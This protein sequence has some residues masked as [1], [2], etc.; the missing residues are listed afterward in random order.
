MIKLKRDK[1]HKYQLAAIDFIKQKKKCALFLDMGLGKTAL[2]LTAVSDFLDDFAVSRVLVIAPLRVANTVWTQE[3]AKW[4]HLEHLTFAVCTG[5]PRERK[6][7]LASNVDI[8]VINRENVSWLVDCVKWRW[9]MVIVD[10]STSFKNFNTMRS[11]ALR[12]VVKYFRYTVLLTG[13]PSPNSLMDL[14][15]QLYL[16]DRGERL[17][18]TIGEY[19]RR[20]F[21][22]DGFTSY[23]YEA[24][25]D[26]END[27]K[28]LIKDVC[29]S[30]KSADY[31][32]LP[33]KVVVRVA[34]ELP[35]QMK[36]LYDLFEKEFLLELENTQVE[37]LTTAAL[38]NKLLQICN[39][40]VY[41]ADKVPHVMHDAKI[42][43]LRDIVADNPAENFLVAYNFKADLD[44][45]TQ[46][47]P[48]AV[49]LDKKG[50]ALEQWNK[51]NI[52]ILLAHP[53][54][55]GH[56]LNAQFGGSA[57]VWFGLNWSLEL[58]QQFNSR[59]YRQGQNK[60]VRIIHIVSKGCY[61]DKVVSALRRKVKTQNDLIE[62]LKYNMGAIHE[63]S[64]NDIDIEL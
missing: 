18:R 61:D 40:F 25:A 56:G 64:V 6:A 1:L 7:A 60:P 59:I 33:S 2:T 39:G 58:Y 26:A 37:A 57:V 50:L 16:I 63:P 28:S 27:V 48:Q 41:D 4:Q 42:D 11:R 3:A 23:K 62:Y 21:T 43:A 17:G 24:V 54:S 55:A 34:V 14:W 38:V 31:L 19:R 44:R 9:D 47:F 52:R 30:M 36:K 32:E 5:S 49:V 51:G 35:P 12:R 46:A 53:A 8:H 10:E 15:A 22:Q 29:V 13:T 45:L 20:F